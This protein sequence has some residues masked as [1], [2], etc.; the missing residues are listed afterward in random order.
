MVFIAGAQPAVGRQENITSSPEHPA[1]YTSPTHADL[2]APGHVHGD[3]PARGRGPAIPSGSPLMIPS[4]S[5]VSGRAQS[6]RIPLSNGESSA[7]ST[8][9]GTG[10]LERNP[11]INY[12]HHRQTSIVHGVAQHSRNS[13]ISSSPAYSHRSPQVLVTGSLQNGFSPETPRSF[14]TLSPDSGGFHPIISPIGAADGS[15]LLFH[16]PP[17]LTGESDG[18]RAHANSFA[19]RRDDRAPV[20]KSRREHGRSSSKPHLDQTSAGEYA[21]HHLFNSVSNQFV[22]RLLLTMLTG[23]YSSSGKQISRLMNALQPSE[24]KSRGLKTYVGRASTMTLIN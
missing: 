11:S 13:S 19:Q 22:S 16:S 17:P 24:T 3:P 2:R 1:Y 10:G 18:F 6:P 9:A 20:G 4:Q 21:L 12:G 8:P 7:R 15:Q 14:N 5:Q 23:E